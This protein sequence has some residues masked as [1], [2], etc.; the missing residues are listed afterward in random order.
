MATHKV[1]SG[2][3]EVDGLDIVSADARGEPERPHAYG[4]RVLQGAF[5]LWNMQRDEN[6]VLTADLV[7]LSVGRFGLPILGS[8][9]FVGGIE[10]FGGEGP[11]L[12]KGAVQNLSATALSVRPGGSARLI[13][14][15]GGLKTHG[16][17]ILPLEQQGTVE[18]LVVDGGCSGALGNH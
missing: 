12:V 2:R 6:V 9:V 10:T 3:I 7:D 8:G 18:R 5:T 13:T 1:R 15:E 16:K 4:V 14:I 17:N 11:S